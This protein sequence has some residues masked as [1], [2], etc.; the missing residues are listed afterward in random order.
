MKLLFGMLLM[1]TKNAILAEYFL[2]TCENF[3]G[4]PKKLGLPVKLAR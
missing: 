1:M 3:I 2:L 4:Y